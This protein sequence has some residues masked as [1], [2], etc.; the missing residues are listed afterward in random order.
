MR[1]QLGEFGIC[2]RLGNDNGSHSDTY[3]RMSLKMAPKLMVTLNTGDKISP[4]PL[5]IVAAKPMS[6]G[7][8]AVCPIDKSMPRR[9]NLFDPFKSGG[10][11][12][13]IGIG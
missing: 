13:D 5:R 6:E 1:R 7:K 10:F 11:L 9:L 8:E 3:T 12:F 2:H 4:K